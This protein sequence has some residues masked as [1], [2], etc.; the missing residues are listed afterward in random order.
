[1]A[2]IKGLQ[3]TSLVDFPPYI[4]CTVFISCCNFRCGFCHNKD[5]VDDS[6]ELKEIKESEILEFL[7]LRKKILDGVCITGGEPTLYPDIKGVISKIKEKGFK[8]KLD[9]NGSNPLILK[10]LIDSRLIDYIAMDIKNSMQRYSETCCVSVDIDKIKDSIDLIKNSDIGYEFRS[11][12]VPRLHS[13]EDVDKI[14]SWLKGSKR[15][16]IQNFRANNNVI[17]DKYKGI[18]GFSR[19]NLMKFKEILMKYIDEVEVRE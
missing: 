7:D 11:T 19:E 3:K 4:S 17:D 12:L 13:K 18:N 2:M 1:M 15:F 16:V 9:T 10:E 6:P 14:G 5:L 8:V